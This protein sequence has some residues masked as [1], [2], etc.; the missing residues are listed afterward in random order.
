M[1]LLDA[2]GGYIAAFSATAVIFVVTKHLYLG[3]SLGLAFGLGVVLHFAMRSHK[4]KHLASIMTVSLLCSALIA[5]GATSLAVRGCT[6]ADYCMRPLPPI[7]NATLVPQRGTNCTAHLVN[8][9]VVCDSNCPVVSDIPH[10]TY[11][12]VN[13]AIIAACLTA[14]RLFGI[15]CLQGHRHNKV[16]DKDDAAAASTDEED[17][18]VCFRVRRCWTCCSSCRRGASSGSNDRAVANISSSGVV[19]GYQ[20]VHHSDDVG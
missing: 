7:A 16:S 17:Q 13:A 3:L 4:V 10:Q 8:M 9:L 11:L 14:V 1:L 18:P 15:L 12:A 6:S 20:R 2:L 19:S 5:Q